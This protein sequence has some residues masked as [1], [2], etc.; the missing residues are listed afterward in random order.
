MECS[1]GITIYDYW[2]ALGK[3]FLSLYVMISEFILVNT[4]HWYL[5][6]QVA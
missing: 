6:K 5:H 2:R 1:V 4:V 3:G